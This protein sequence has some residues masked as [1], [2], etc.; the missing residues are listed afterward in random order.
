[1]NIFNEYLSKIDNLENRTKL[2]G[3]LEWIIHK[4]PHL[5]PKIA[6]NQPMFTDHNTYII[7]FSVSKEHLAIGPEIATINQFSDEIHLAG[8]DHSMMLMRIKWDKSVNYTLL[9]RMIDYNILEKKD[10]TTFWRK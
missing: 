4:Y 3:V 7:G 2:E 1:M 8:Y 6:W 10:T 9:E 5:V